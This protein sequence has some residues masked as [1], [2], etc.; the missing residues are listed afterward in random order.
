MNTPIPPYPEKPPFRIP[1][2]KDQDMPWLRRLIVETV[3]E[4]RE[5]QEATGTVAAIHG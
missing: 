4:L 3:A 1:G 5:L 2:I